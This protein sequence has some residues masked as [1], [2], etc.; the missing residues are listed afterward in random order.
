MNVIFAG[1]NAN[2]VEE[3]LLKKKLNNM[4]IIVI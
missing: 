4:K 1:K 2:F 3:Y